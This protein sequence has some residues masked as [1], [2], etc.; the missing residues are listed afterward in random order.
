LMFRVH[1]RAEEGRILAPTKIEQSP[2]NYVPVAVCAL[3]LRV[4]K[5]ED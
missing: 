3:A 4:P 1:S 5:P 2:P